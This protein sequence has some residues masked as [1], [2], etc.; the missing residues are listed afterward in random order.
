MECHLSCGTSSTTATLL[1]VALTI[2]LAALVLLLFHLPSLD[3]NAAKPLPIIE[4]RAVYHTS[5]DMPYRLNYDSRIV[6][7]HNGTASLENRPLKARIYKNNVLLPAS[8]T[9]L[10]GHD[11]ISTAH[12]DVQ[13]IGGAGCSGSLWTFGEVLVID[14]SDNTLHPDDRVRVEILSGPLNSLISKDT[15]VA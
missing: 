12:Y 4:I 9:T 3:W 2:T 10:N 14:L 13:W 5:E 1:L 8:I 11:F 15:A 6:L 7:V